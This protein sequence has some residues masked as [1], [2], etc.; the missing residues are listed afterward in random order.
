MRLCGGSRNRSTFSAPVRTPSGTKFM[1][2]CVAC[3]K[4]TSQIGGNED[5]ASSL[6]QEVQT[7][8]RQLNMKVNA[9]TQRTSSKRGACRTAGRI[10]EIARN[11]V[12]LAGM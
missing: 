6:I 7:R 9:L 5:A 4:K 3:S 2:Q 1:A 12:H 11:T 10:K 8:R